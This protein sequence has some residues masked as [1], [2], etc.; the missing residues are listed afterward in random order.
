MHDDEIQKMVDTLCVTNPG[1]AK[2]VAGSHERAKGMLQIAMTFFLNRLGRATAKKAIIDFL[3]ELDLS[4]AAE[5][6]SGDLNSALPPTAPQDISGLDLSSVDGR[7]KVMLDYLETRPAAQAVLEARAS[8][9]ASAAFLRL[10]CSEEDAI[11]HL[12]FVQARMSLAA[13]FEQLPVASVA[14]N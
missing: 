12:R 4:V 8:I 10:R 13:W 11:E 3:R 7:A 9:L 1:N 6:S 2:M 14:R 5:S